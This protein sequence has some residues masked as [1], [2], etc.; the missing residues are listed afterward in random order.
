M[1]TPACMLVHLK[2]AY[3]LPLQQHSHQLHL[4][5]TKGRGQYATPCVPVLTARGEHSSVVFPLHMSDKETIL[6]L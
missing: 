2:Y 5:C 3:T 6:T 1:V 4:V